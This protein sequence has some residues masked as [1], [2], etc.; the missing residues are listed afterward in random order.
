VYIR[1][2]C[3]LGQEDTVMA[4]KFCITGTCVPEKNYMVDISDRIDRI[5]KDYIEQGQY[6]TINRARQYGKTTTLFLLERKLREDY[7]VL[8]LSF[9]AADEYFESL[10][11]LAEGLVLDIG[12]CLREQNVAEKT[13]ND[14]ISPLSEKFPMRSLGMKITSLCKSCGK[15]IVLM[16]DEV[17]K[18]SDNQIF[19]SF[20][21]LL[22]EKY[23]KWQQGK[24]STFQSVVL[25]G[26]H[27]V[28]T[29]KLKLHPQE[30]S[31]YNSPW[32][33]AVDF[34]LD[35]SFS[36]KDI[37]SMLNEYERDYQTGMNIR[38]ISQLIY[39]YTSGY[40][41]LVS[42]ICQIMDERIL[43]TD[44]FLTNVLVWTK[45]GVLEA[46]KLLLKEPNTLFDDM[47]KKLLDYPK[48]KEMMQSILF[49]GVSFPFKRETPLI[50]LGVTFGFLKD[51]HGIV[52]ISNRIF[53]TQLYDLFLAEMAINDA[54]YVAA[55]SDRNQFIISGMLQMDLVM[56]KFYE[57]FEEIYSD[58][59]Q[60][61]IEENGRK[62]FLLYLKPIINGTG[63]YYIEART[64]D[65]KR[66][67]IIIDYRGKQFIIE[68]KIWHGDEYN[69]RGEKQLFE[70]LEIYKQE[71]GYLLSFNFNKQKKTGIHEIRYKEKKILEVVV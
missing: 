32:N 44:E 23:L 30:E 55:V 4:K 26:V 37:E 66:T 18:S 56:K 50:N 62:L 15:K 46:V 6:F 51:N 21:G 53:E 28:K 36:V 22:R 54:M 24:D 45:E 71:R 64:R 68:L 40:P 29:L 49:S 59:D 35:M 34:R 38:E 61:F 47:T 2:V 43:G 5:T 48:L 19:L 39:D 67:D 9:E 42:R 63:N 52:A 65:N 17:D 25:A 41:Y 1:L 57:H 58:N 60:K 3:K 14:W 11:S 33:I 27:D 12:E 16:I 10:T 13:V 8:S 69:K 70:Y 20:L 31:K 7:L